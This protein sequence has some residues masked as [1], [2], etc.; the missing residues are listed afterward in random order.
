MDSGI[1]HVLSTDG[2]ELCSAVD[3]LE[4]GD[5][6]QRLERVTCGNIIKSNMGKCKV[7]HL[8]QGN[9]KHEH[10][11]GDEWNDEQFWKEGL[12]V[13]VGKNLHMIQQSVFTG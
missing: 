5:T 8:G 1:K 12:G 3:L 10:R 9:P 11:L 13:F 7:L 4:W 2:T 6:I